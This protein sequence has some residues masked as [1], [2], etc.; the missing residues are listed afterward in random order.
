MGN[1][2]AETTAQGQARKRTPDANAQEVIAGRTTA[3]SLYAVTGAGKT[4]I[5]AARL[6][7][8]S[9]NTQ[10]GHRRLATDTTWAGRASTSGTNTSGGRRRAT[11]DTPSCFRRGST[12]PSIGKNGVHSNTTNQGNNKVASRDQDN[13]AGTVQRNTASQEEEKEGGQRRRRRRI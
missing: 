10:G 12:A 1:R 2:T 6:Q 3:D 9:T 8:S 5:G 11:K 7:D 13:S 4:G